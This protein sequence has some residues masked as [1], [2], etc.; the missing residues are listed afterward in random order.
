VSEVDQ[1][2]SR[3]LSGMPGLTEI[4]GLNNLTAKDTQRDYATL[5]IVL[6]PRLVRGPQS[7]GHSPM[8]RIERTKLGQ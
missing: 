6:T 3:A 2:E 8:M 7:F 4:P 5:L 1:Q